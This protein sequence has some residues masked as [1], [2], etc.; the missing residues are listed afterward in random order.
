MK[1][2]TA[3]PQF[4]GECAILMVSGAQDAVFYTA[5]NG[6]LS[7]HK[8]IAVAAP[9]YSDNEGFFAARASGRRGDGTLRSGAVRELNKWE[10]RNSFIKEAATYLKELQ[11]AHDAKRMFVFAPG[12]MLNALEGHL[13]K[14]IQSMIAK[15][16][17]GEY[18][19]E[20]PFRLLE[21]IAATKQVPVT[22]TSKEAQKILRK[23][24]RAGRK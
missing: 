23:T 14:R 19:H 11:L 4:T 13:P 1:I 7:K 22:P 20:H 15:H 5:K 18:A 12:Y 2:S 17:R 24:S 10:T 6:V 3:L 21:K 16:F 9:K 8:R